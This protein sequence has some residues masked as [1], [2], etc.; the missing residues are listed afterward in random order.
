[1]FRPARM[2][3]LSI[4]TL[5]QYT[6][7]V[8]DVLHERGVI[9]IDDLSEQIQEDEEFKGLDVSI[10]DPHASRI[11]SLSMKC[12]S[13]LDT[14]K[15][16][17]QSKSMVEVIKGFI[18]PKEI[19]A[20]EVENIP[21]EELADK[22]EEI[23]NKVDAVLSPIESRL[24]DIGSEETKYNDS[25]N[26]ATQLSSFDI[27]FAYLQD[28]KHTKVIAGNIPEDYVSEAENEIEEVT[29]QVAVFKG[30]SNSQSDVTYV[31]VIIV[32]TNE[33][34]EEISGVLRRHEFEKLD[35]SGLSGKANEI[36]EMSKSKLEDCENE[37]K[38]C[39]KDIR[40]VGQRSKE[41]LLAL[42]EQLDF[43]KERTEI[44]SYFGET[45]STKMFK[46]WVVK[47]DVDE[48]LSIIDQ[49]TEG[50]SIVEVTDPTDEEIDNNKVPVKQRNPAFAKPYE[51]LVNMYS[52]PNY[53]DID[54]TIIMALFYPFLFGYCLTE[55]FY[56]F[57]L[58]IIGF[59][60]Y[61]G[62]GKYKDTY[63][64]I[65]IIIIQ[66]GL[67]TVIMGLATNGFL[68]DFVPRFIW[69]DANLALPTV[70]PDIN[71]F[72]HPENILILGI[73]IGLIHLNIAF[74]FGIIDNLKRHQIKDMI[75]GQL[76]WVLVEISIV[77]YLVGGI[78]PFAVLFV[79]AMLSLIYA[80]GPMGVMD[81]FGFL[82]NVLSY[83]RLLALCL[84][85]GGI[86]MT[87]NLLSQLL[88][89]SIPYVGIIIGA[90]IFLGVHIFNISF[91]TLGASIHP[92]RLHFVE[93]FGT[94][95]TGESELFTP[96]KSERIYTKLKK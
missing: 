91:Q 60:V 46:A 85:T 38:E 17:E 16:A 23:I 65:S 20:K 78:V 83:S 8:I 81:I 4:V 32:C 87:G 95:Y 74:I 15:S 69:G 77:L 58:A 96:F 44:Y 48:T 47:D 18:S 3:K 79:I 92:L 76:A 11:A 61:R 88:A 93:F 73:I 72:A 67:W 19:P 80:S 53:K 52:T 31:P 63:K 35:V 66:C 94:F 36:I 7:P 21:T 50:N 25:L 41:T 24:G 89:N 71:A 55:S 42:N 75:G 14:L 33:F 13:V 39:L 28:T 9:Q 30:S 27:D 26:I 68:G 57:I 59:L 90:I 5:N 6:K 1:M 37:R 10:Q 43:E 86:A 49:V 62:I 64:A 54:P 51:L 56:G 82:G 2:Q 45:K 22:A 12:G 70:L 34:E 40:E 29:D 84:S